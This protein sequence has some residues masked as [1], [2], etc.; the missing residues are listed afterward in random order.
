MRS[1]IIIVGVLFFA[2]CNTIRV[3]YDYDK[4]T[5]FTNYSTY[6]YYPD[7]DTGLSPLDAK[8]LL[9]AVNAEM[10]L[11]GI[12]FSEDPDFFINIESNSFQAPRSNTVG[13]GLGGSGRS[14]GGGV[15]VGIPV[16]QP[17]LEREIR[18]DFVDA[19]KDELFWQGQGFSNF[20]ENVSPETREEKLHALAAKVF[21]KYPPKQ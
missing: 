10:Q 15:S 11:K 1:I 21:S 6:N 7:M 19:K 13:V 8:R 3:N 16:G 12:R 18:F 4:N 5:D 14:V 17:K 20:K 2:S 9:D